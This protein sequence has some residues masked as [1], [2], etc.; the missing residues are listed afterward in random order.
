M[1]ELSSD[2]LNE[3]RVNKIIYPILI[4]IGVI[5]YMLYTEIKQVEHLQIVPVGCKVELT[6]WKKLSNDEAHRTFNLEL[7]DT[8][9]PKKD[10][11]SFLLRYHVEKPNGSVSLEND[12][13][14]FTTLGQANTNHSKYIEK[15]ARTSKDLI[16]FDFKQPVQSVFSA[17]DFTFT[18]LFWLLM[19]FLMMAIRDFGYMLRIRVLTDNDLS[20]RQSFNLIMLWEFSSAVTPSAVGGSG[21]AIYL[22]NREGLSVGRSTAVVMSS[23]FLDELYFLL[24]IPLLFL[25]V[26]G[27]TLF[28]IGG[29]SQA[30]SFAN[31]FF[32]F[33]A[34]SYAVILVFTSFLGYGLFI[35]PRSME[36]LLL[37]IFKLPILKRWRKGAVQT[38]EDLIISSQELKSKSW[39]FWLKAFGSTIFSW[40]GRYWIVNILLL[41]LIASLV[42][43]HI[44]LDHFL[45]FARQ[46]VMWIMMII[47]PTP[48][49]SGF[50]EFVFSN[51]L[52]EFIPVGFA[53]A[54]ALLWR[55][56]SYYPYL[57]IG[58]I[59]LPRWI[60]SKVLKPKVKPNVS[61]N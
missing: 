18:S 20:W 50:A 57:F 61:N 13:V 29:A 52:G 49:G 15:A 7:I 9:L 43:N 48:G 27:S 2:S 60:K 39:G 21:V 42:S 54:L 23:I 40:T 10:T 47:S 28:S 38:A 25:V 58:A 56:I 33:A 51:Y 36:R 46:L 24:A 55:L 37:W 4:G 12:T 22:V 6:E 44:I 17:L 8:I 1:T 3:I 53:V 31:E 11:L 19:A 26:S 14:V 32:L 41:G 30:L 45:I 5:L 35:N 34:I 16:I 59:I